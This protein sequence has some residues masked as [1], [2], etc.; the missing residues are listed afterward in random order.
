MKF[1]NLILAASIVA[2]TFASCN[3]EDEAGTGDNSL[4]SVTISLAN[5]FRAPVPPYLTARGICPKPKST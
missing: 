3:K 2:M 5:V 4:K 1:S